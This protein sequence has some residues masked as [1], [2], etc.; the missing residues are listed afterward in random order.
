[1][2]N[3]EGGTSLTEAAVARGLRW[4]SKHQ[5]TNGSWSL[6]EFHRAGDCNG[7]C[8]GAGGYTDT[9]AT[10]LALLPFLGAGQT[11]L[12]GRY[13][14]TVKAG[15]GY[16]LNQQQPDGSL[17]GNGNGQMYA[18]GIATIVLCEAFALTGDKQLRDPAE[19]AVN[20]IVKAQHRGGGWRYGPG[21]P[22]D[23]SVVGWQLMALRSATMAGFNVP[24]DVFERAGHFLDQVASDSTGALYSYQPGHPASPTMTAEGLLCREYLGWPKDHP[25]LQIGAAVLV[26]DYLPNRSQANIY[27]WYYATQVLHHIGG[28]DWEKWNSAI[29]TA[30]LE[31]QETQGHEAGSWDPRGGVPTVGNVDVQTGGRIYMTSLAIC[32]L[33]VYY[34]HL[35]IYRAIELK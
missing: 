14:Q 31:M 1:V 29:R 5:D 19:R 9:G 25:G 18:N 28:D 33:E 21:Q 17:I 30:L 20:F 23:T 26:R 2:L 10:A 24:D 4:L 8:R 35:P 16:L 22:G 7:Q 32:T 13:S 12:H 6:S 3:R 11:H 34:R 27:F 15:L